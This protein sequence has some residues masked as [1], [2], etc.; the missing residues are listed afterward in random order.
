MD[1]KICRIGDYKINVEATVVSSKDKALAPFNTLPANKITKYQIQMS[2]YANILQRS[3]W[4]VQGLDV[5]ILEDG[6]QYYPL[7]VL[8]VIV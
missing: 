2:I 3:G 1:K 5:Y 8:K 6:W 4:T 7:E